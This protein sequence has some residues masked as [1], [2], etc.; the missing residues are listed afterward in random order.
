MRKR[1]VWSFPNSK[2]IE[3]GYDGRYGAPGIQ[4]GKR[5]KPT[6]EEVKKQNQRNR[7]NRVRRLIKANF[8]K[9]DYWTTLT[10]EKGTRPTAKDLKKDAEAFIR[11]LRKE[12][13]KQG[14]V[15]KYIIRMEIG[16]NG[17]PHLHLLVN[18]VE[19]GDCLINR[20]WKKGHCNLKFLY[21]E[22]DFRKLA[23][24]LTKEKGEQEPEELK[25]YS[26]SRNLIVPKPRV[27]KLKTKTW[28]EAKAPKGWYIDK[29][30]YYEG[31]NPVTGRK[32][33]QYTLLR[34]KRRE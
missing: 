24:Y 3:E 28:Q 25:R 20:C 9:E 5:R 30:T 6:Q 7:E 23:Q 2:E 1:K 33:R 21:E 31:I 4:R 34:I 13:K 18:R 11:K 14:K 10:Y 29:E 27:Y 16:K 32:Y 17:G 15:L 22:G 26:R 19:G 8:R 12:Y